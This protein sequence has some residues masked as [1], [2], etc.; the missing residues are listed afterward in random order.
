MRPSPVLQHARFENWEWPG[1]EANTTL[2]VDKTEKFLTCV[3][4]VIELMGLGSFAL[5][6]CST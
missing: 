5:T 2:S 3:D 4:F 6:N 1:D